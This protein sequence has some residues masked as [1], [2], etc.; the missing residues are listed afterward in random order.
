MTLGHGQTVRPSAGRNASTGE[1]DQI[2]PDDV[3]L[4]VISAA[5][6][7]MPFGVIMIRPEAEV[8]FTNEYA[9][10]ILSSPGGLVVKNGQLTAENPAETATIRQFI[11]SVVRRDKSKERKG[12]R[13]AIPVSR[14]GGRPLSVII[15][16]LGCSASSSDHLESL[17][18]IFVGDPA[19]DQ[20]AHDDVLIKLY[21]LTHTE[22][23]LT[24]ALLKGQ[25]LEWA[26]K[27][28][29]MSLNTA[30][31]HLR[32]VFGKTGTS[33]QAELVR[34]ILRSPAILR[35]GLVR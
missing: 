21:G 31:T 1:I 2:L 4:E 33:R 12:V 30:K 23:A 18:A 28:T 24:L 35:F 6:N 13:Y 15:A 10:R 9:M 14:R 29:R 11:Q 32:H 3:R 7:C 5:L 17:V 16:P 22:A 26:A 25:G 27:K 19:L 34:L 20:E 8:V